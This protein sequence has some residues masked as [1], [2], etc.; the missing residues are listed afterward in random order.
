MKTDN[1]SP[2][3]G[4]TEFGFYPNP[5]EMETHRF[6]ITTKPGLSE[7]VQTLADHEHTV[8]GWIY[9]G[10]AINYDLIKGKKAMPYPARL[11][12]LPQTH[13]LTLYGEQDESRIDFVLWCLSFLLG[14]RLTSMP[15]AYIDATPLRP[16]TLND[17]VMT[18]NEREEAIDR[19]IDFHNRSNDAIVL[20]RVAA[21][22]HSLFIAQNPKNFP[23]ER[24]QYYYMALDTCYK[25]TKDIADKKQPKSHAL[26]V[27]W[28]C[29]HFRIPTPWWAQKKS[30]GNSTPLSDVRNDTIHEGLFFGE[31]LGFARYGG[32][33]ATEQDKMVLLEMRGI[34]CR[35]LIAI[36]GTSEARYVKTEPDRFQHELGLLTK[37]I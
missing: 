37:P 25:L 10:P 5:L 2:L 35:L 17:F 22:I 8:Q 15:M 18:M 34:V 4:G 20:K 33:D 11:F 16:G 32:Q 1:V 3:T 31:P 21:A 19:C 7:T 27:E 30:K 13:T 28:A 6:S 36:L 9:S 24:F 14:M 12:G 23:F 29:E 26:R